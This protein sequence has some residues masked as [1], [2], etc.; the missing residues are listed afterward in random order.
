MKITLAM[1]RQH[2]ACADQVALFQQHFGTEVEITESVCVAVA[3]LFDWEWA[4]R[5]LLTAPAQDA[6]DK[7]TASAQDAYNK[8]KARAFA[9]CFNG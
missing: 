1:L 5:H 7:A 8:A 6:Y 3:P 2:N 4:A 9:R